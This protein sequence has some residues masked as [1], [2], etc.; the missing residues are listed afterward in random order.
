VVEVA[1]K[2][3]GAPYRQVVTPAVGMIVHGRIPPQETS[4]GSQMSAAKLL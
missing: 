1:M 3:K 4:Q 2:K